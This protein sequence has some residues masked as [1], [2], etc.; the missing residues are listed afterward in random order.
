M[1]KNEI[2]RIDL[3]TVVTNTFTKQDTKVNIVIVLYENYITHNLS[4]KIHCSS[5]E[6]FIKS[7]FQGYLEMWRKGIY[8]ISRLKQAILAA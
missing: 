4:Y 2:G 7:E 6:S 3:N 8:T 5:H 1:F